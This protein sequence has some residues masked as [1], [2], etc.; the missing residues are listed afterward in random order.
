MQQPP[1]VV[2]GAPGAWGMGVDA[3]AC[4]CGG[5]AVEQ[6]G[7]STGP[8]AVCSR[9]PCRFPEGLSPLPAEPQDILTNTHIAQHEWKAGWMQLRGSPAAP[10]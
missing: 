4:V 3:L 6:E 7:V 10:P 2:T 8:H 5:E 1:K 9:M